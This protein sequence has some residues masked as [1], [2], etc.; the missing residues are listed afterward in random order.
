MNCS[1]LRGAQNAQTYSTVES[2]KG[3]GHTV[4]N[5]LIIN[6]WLNGPAS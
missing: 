2:D 5:I 3:Q 6:I 4:D 1:P